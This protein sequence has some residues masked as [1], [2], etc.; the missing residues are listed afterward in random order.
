MTRPYI[1]K[2]LK[3]GCEVI[4]IDL[5]ASISTQVI[6]QIKQDVTEHRI[7]VFRDQ[8]S[9]TP[10]RHVEIGTWF[11]RIEST[12]YNH[13]RSPLRD[14]FRVSND[15]TE[16]CVNVGRTGWHVDGSFQVLEFNRKCLSGLLR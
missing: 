16:G 4:G 8:L 9:L 6:E 12:F 11:G 14:I 3:L 13:P 15:P 2:P 5:S 7:L 1:L 10:E